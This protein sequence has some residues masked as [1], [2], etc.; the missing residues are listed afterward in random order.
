MFSFTFQVGVEGENF[1]RISAVPT[2]LDYSFVTLAGLS[3]QM[4]LSYQA[5]GFPVD[6]LD[7]VG[8]TTTLIFTVHGKPPAA[9]GIQALKLSKSVPRV[10]LFCCFLPKVY[11]YKGTIEC[12]ICYVVAYQ[13]ARLPPL[14][15]QGSDLHMIECQ[16]RLLWQDDLKR[17]K[18]LN[19]EPLF[20]NEAVP[21][22]YFNDI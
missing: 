1:A 3:L 16:I 9:A 6:E 13:W 17:G 19:I 14:A 15:M 11:L 22:I 2:H 10:Y 21:K 5:T 12:P 8:E 4:G 18:M 7:T 20:C